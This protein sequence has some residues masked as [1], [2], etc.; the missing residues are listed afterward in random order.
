MA[1]NRDT[2]QFK[3]YTVKTDTTHFFLLQ[4]SPGCV[5]EAWS[6]GVCVNF[7]HSGETT[8]PWRLAGAW[9]AWAG[10]A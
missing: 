7:R 8:P 4:L 10:T 1:E 3:C 5:S 2:V 9:P 6:R